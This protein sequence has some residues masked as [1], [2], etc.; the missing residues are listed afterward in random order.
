MQLF[1][2][3]DPGMQR[4]TEK[5]CTI[6]AKQFKIGRKEHQCKKCYRA[7]C[8]DC[9]KE[10]TLVFMQGF[11]QEPHRN[12]KLCVQETK[13]LKDYINVN[14]IAFGNMSVLGEKWLKKIQNSN[15]LPKT[16]FKKSSIFNREMFNMMWDSYNYS[17]REFIG[18]LTF[19][20][21]QE[22][23]YGQVVDVFSNMQSVFP[24]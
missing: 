24:N 19:N 6:C 22:D 15:E 14:K 8:S 11:L 7:V 16:Q 21:S 3:N 20:S 9:G 1:E 17:M 2:R 5:K 18:L 4:D 23:V 12:C 13:G 10:K